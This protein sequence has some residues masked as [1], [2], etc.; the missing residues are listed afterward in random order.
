MLTRR[1]FA[2]VLTPPS[3]VLDKIHLHLLALW[4]HIL[5]AW[6]NFYKMQTH[7][8]D[9]IKKPRRRAVSV[10]GDRNT[11]HFGSNHSCLNH[12]RVSLPHCAKH[13]RGEPGEWQDHLGSPPQP[14]GRNILPSKAEGADGWRDKAQCNIDMISWDDKSQQDPEAKCNMESF[15]YVTPS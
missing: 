7:A 3:H 5:A 4:T 9:Y 1:W 2:S 8:F 12:H 11:R 13:W 6:H 14:P 10:A 15:I